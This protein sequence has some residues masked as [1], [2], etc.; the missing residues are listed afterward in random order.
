MTV[1]ADLNRSPT[2]ALLPGA[3]DES[4][5]VTPPK[6]VRIRK[7]RRS[8]TYPVCRRLVLVG[9]LIASVRDSPFGC[10]SYVTREHADGRTA[11]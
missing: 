10:L 1:S 7:A 6:H 3:G 4:H 5:P 11:P 2:F 9:E 8:G